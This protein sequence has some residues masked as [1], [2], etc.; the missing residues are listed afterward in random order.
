MVVLHFLDQVVVRFPRWVL[1][2]NPGTRMARHWP[3]IRHHGGVLHFPTTTLEQGP[4][5]L[6]TPTVASL[7]PHEDSRD[8]V[9]TRQLKLLAGIQDFAT[10][11]GQAQCARLSPNAGN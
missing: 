6:L 11:M 3:Y 9:F 1:P 8:R 10:R 2:G 7:Q 5:L 4:V